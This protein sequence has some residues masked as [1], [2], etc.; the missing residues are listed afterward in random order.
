MFIV[1]T[2]EHINSIVS[3]CNAGKSPQFGD[4]YFPFYV[5]NGEFE[6]SYRS[7]RDFCMGYW[8]TFY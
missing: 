5:D 3:L 7:C 4:I 8:D 2:D 6:A 1:V